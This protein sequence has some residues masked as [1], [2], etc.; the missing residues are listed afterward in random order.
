MSHHSSVVALILL[1]CFT[2]RG[3]EVALINATENDEQIPTPSKKVCDRASLIFPIS[4]PSSVRLSVESDDLK[5][6]TLILSFPSAQTC[7]T[8]LSVQEV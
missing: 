2:N 4:V 8:V 1:A 3:D 6:G 5:G 7:K